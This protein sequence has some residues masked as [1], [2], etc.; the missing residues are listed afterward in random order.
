MK[1]ERNEKLL[2][3]IDKAIATS[4]TYLEA[5]DKIIA[6][7]KTKGLVSWHIS[8]MP[9]DDSD[10]EQIAKET[11]EIMREFAEGKCKEVDVT[12]L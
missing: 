10:P 7:K 9:N 11:I 6:Y 8:I 3:A 12:N 4:K 1:N 2:K 5:L